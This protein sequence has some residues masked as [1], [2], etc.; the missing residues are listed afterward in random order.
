MKSHPISELE[1]P[2]GGAAITHY[3][4]EQDGDD[5][6]FFTH[7]R[8]DHEPHGRQPDQRPDLHVQG[9]GGEQRRGERGYR[10]EVGHV[11]DDSDDDPDPDLTRPQRSRRWRRG[12]SR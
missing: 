9:A 12:S 6:W 10:F 11:D 2:P 4:Y 1:A 5:K 3:E 7:G 8:D